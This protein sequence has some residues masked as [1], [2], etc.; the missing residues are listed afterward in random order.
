MCKTCYRTSCQEQHSKSCTLKD[1]LRK[2]CNMCHGLVASKPI[3]KKNSVPVSYVSAYSLCGNCKTHAIITINRIYDSIRNNGANKLE[4]ANQYKDTADKIKDNCIFCGYFSKLPGKKLCI[5]CNKHSENIKDGTYTSGSWTKLRLPLEQRRDV[6][7]KKDEIKKRKKN[8]T[9]RRKNKIKKRKNNNSI[10]N[11]NPSS[12]RIKN[13]NPSSSRIKNNNTISSISK[14]NNTSISRIKS[15]SPSCSRS[16]NNN[17]TPS[18]FMKKIDP[19]NVMKLK[20]YFETTFRN[21]FSLSVPEKFS[22]DQYLYG[23]I[24]PISVSLQT[25]EIILPYL[26]ESTL[27]SVIKD[28]INS[29]E[30]LQLSI[31]TLAIVYCLKMYTHMDFT[32]CH[33]ENFICKRSNTTINIRYWYNNIAWTVSFESSFDIKIIDLDDAYIS[34]FIKISRNNNSTFMTAWR[35]MMYKNRLPG[36]D[37]TL[38]AE[39]VLHELCMRYKKDYDMTQIHSCNISPPCY[40]Q[41]TKNKKQKT[42]K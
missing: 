26:G 34:N 14:N 20:L 25:N 27:G 42:K 39:S 5:E 22:E 31:Q 28:G 1:C 6:N 2:M 37:K 15:T 33:S 21:T 11:N 24:Y 3:V 12:S 8:K 29:K 7:L 30:K 32:D 13:N 41:K 16:K 36:N 23:A 9:K 35:H 19:A 17:T 4:D 10:I 38:S 18:V 40:Q